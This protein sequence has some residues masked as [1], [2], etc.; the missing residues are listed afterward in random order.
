MDGEGRGVTT[1]P[2]LV[3]WLNKLE[4]FSSLRT[5]SVSSSFYALEDIW[6]P[7]ML[8]KTCLML[9]TLEVLAISGDLTFSHPMLDWVAYWVARKDALSMGNSN[10]TKSQADKCSI[11]MVHIGMTMARS[12]HCFGL[13]RLFAR[14]PSENISIDMYWSI[15][16]LWIEAISTAY[17]Y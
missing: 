16:P 8:L 9:G 2:L 11:L 7:L 6:K 15:P 10:T 3:S 5:F 13:A 14:P 17:H 4:G 12:T 1:K